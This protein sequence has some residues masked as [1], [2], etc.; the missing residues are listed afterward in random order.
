MQRSPEDVKLEQACDLGD[1]KMCRALLASRPNF[2]STLSDVDRRRLT[3]A[4]QN[5]NT[6]AL[7]LMLAAGWP[8]DAR[9]RV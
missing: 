7:R 9:G 4:A 2:V 5:N 6:D 3:D 8:V 1:E